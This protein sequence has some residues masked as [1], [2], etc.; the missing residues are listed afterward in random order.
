MRSQFDNAKRV[1][2]LGC[3][4]VLPRPRY[5]AKTATRELRMLLNNPGYADA[6]TRVGKAV[7]EEDG[8]RVAADE[9]ERVL[10]TN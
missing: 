9:I 5:N 4:R 7:R 8:T 2:R 6:A 10:N 1:V 3:A